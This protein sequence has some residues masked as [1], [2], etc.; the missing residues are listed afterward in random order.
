MWPYRPLESRFLFAT[1]ARSGIVDD[2]RRANSKGGIFHHGVRVGP[3][4]FELQAGWQ[5][6]F[7]EVGI[8][9][10]GQPPQSLVLPQIEDRVLPELQTMQFRARQRLATHRRTGSG[11]SISPRE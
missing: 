1:P 6:D 2:G 9:A 3:E 4:F 5:D 11:D 8:A 7:F 10:H